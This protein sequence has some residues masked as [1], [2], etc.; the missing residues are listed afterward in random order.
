M[1]LMTE[2]ERWDVYLTGPPTKPGQGNTPQEALAQVLQ[3]DLQSANR[4]LAAIPVRV[5]A[6]L[7]RDVARRIFN[8]IVFI[9]GTA[10]AVQAGTTAP[11]DSVRPTDSNRVRPAQI[12]RLRND[13]GG[14]RT[15]VPRR[16]IT[17]PHRLAITAGSE[18]VFT[19]HEAARPATASR[20]VA[21]IAVVGMVDRTSTGSQSSIRAQSALTSGSSYAAPRGRV[22]GGGWIIPT[23]L[24]LV[25]A[26]AFV[27]VPMRLKRMDPV[28]IQEVVSTSGD[29]PQVGVTFEF[30]ATPRDLATF[31]ISLSGTAVTNPGSVQWPAISAQPPSNGT[32]YRYAFA[33]EDLIDEYSEGGAAEVLIAFDGQTHATGSIDLAALR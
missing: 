27:V 15:V 4:A 22:S 7:E 8:A 20:S 16:A 21:R 23:A 29:A 33:I 13:S 9:G 24:F 19:A 6:N 12:D 5:G 17:S 1:R 18:Q 26:I 2:S 31:S 28:E 25:A 30:E 32:P 14:E 10:R 3:C 11:I